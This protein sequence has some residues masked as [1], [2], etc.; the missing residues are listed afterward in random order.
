MNLVESHVY[1]A[2]VNICPFRDVSERQKLITGWLEFYAKRTKPK[3]D[4]NLITFEKLF[5]VPNYDSVFLRI[6]KAKN[7]LDTDGSWIGLSFKQTDVTSLIKV[8][9]KNGYI[10]DNLSQEIVGRVFCNK[11]KITLSESSMRHQSKN[12]KSYDDAYESIFPIRVKK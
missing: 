3:T 12:S 10:R 6:L 8:L 5:I 2:F 11:F 1:K 9:K 4:T 7:I